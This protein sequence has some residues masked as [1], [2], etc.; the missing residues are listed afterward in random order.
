MPAH[1]WINLHF[2]L[3]PAWRG[4][5]PVQAA[6]AAGDAVTG[7][8]TFQIE[9]A[10]DSGPVYGVVTETIRPTDTAGDLLDRLSISGAALLETTL[11]GIADGTL[12][13]VPQPS[14]GV[15]VAP[16]VTVDDARVRWDLPAHVVDRRIRAVTP[17]PGAWTMVGDLR[18]KLGPVSIDDAAREP[19]A[20]GAIRVD[21]SGVRVGT[22]SQPVLLGRVQPPGKKPM[23]AA[24]WARGARLDE[25]ATRVMTKPDAGRAASRSIQP[26]ARRSTCCARCLSATPTPTWRCP[27]CCASAASPAA[28]PPSP[29]NWPTAPAAPAGCSTPSSRVPP[30]ARRRTSD[31]VLLDLLRLGTYQLLRTRVDAA[32]RGVH[33]RRAGRHRIRFGASGFRQRRAAHHRIGATSSPGSTSWRRPPTPTPSVTSRSCTPTRAGSPRRSPT[34]SAPT[35]D[36]LDALLSRRRRAAAGASRRAARRADRG[37]PRR[38]GGRNRRPLLAVR[39]LPGRRRPGS[40]G[41]RSATA[42]RWF[43]TRAASWWPRALTLAPVD[44]DGGR[45]LDLCAGPGGKT[46]L[47]AAIGAQWGARVTAIEPNSRRAEFVEENTRGLAVDVLRVDGR[48][49]GIEAG[50]DRVLVDAPCTGLGA[51][52]RRPEAR[53]RRQPEDVPA[54]ARLQRELLASA[55]KLTRPGGVVLYATC[56]PHLSETVG[57]VADALRRQPV[58]ALDTRP[59]FEGSR[60]TRRRAVRA[61]VAAPARHRRDVRGRAVSRVSPCPDR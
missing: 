32:R 60:A 61:A 34:R 52:R 17:N 45:W 54:L 59:L 20:P 26:A 33:H 49:P 30:D 38:S 43:R 31:P 21:R 5:A 9:P 7:A 24:D 47:L 3:L 19:L 41:R 51:L 35:P 53:W 42:R 57:V 55:I 36:E 8:T 22:A 46:A 56:S 48:D 10:L 13:P 40:A 37:R 39:G 44:G 18:V 12:A 14:D 29:P 2:S 4:A 58:T 27:R 1:G 28:T 23:D 6:I 11:D 15:T 25:A 50:F 16:K